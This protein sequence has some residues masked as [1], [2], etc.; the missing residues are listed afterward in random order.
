MKIETRY[1]LGDVV[2]GL[3]TYPA[4]KKNP[5]GLCSATGKVTI[6]GGPRTTQCPDCFGRGGLLAVEQELHGEIDR[7]TIGQVNVRVNYADTDRPSPSTYMAEETGVGTG[8]VWSED[9]LYPGKDE[10]EKACIDAGAI[11]QRVRERAQA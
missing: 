10:A 8:R 7:L 1:S 11:L 4:G 6:A 5:C 3:T 2:W 9:K